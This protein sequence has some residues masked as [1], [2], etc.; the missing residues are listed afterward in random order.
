METSPAAKSD[1]ISGTGD[2]Q[3]FEILDPDDVRAVPDTVDFI[4]KVKAISPSIVRGPKAYPRLP[5]IRALLG[6]YLTNSRIN[7]VTALQYALANKLAL[8]DVGGFDDWVPDRT[9][10]SRIFTAMA[11][12]PDIMD[13]LGA[14][15]VVSMQRVLPDLG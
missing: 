6:G 8:K 3:R 15:V 2:L 4:S 10:L 11:D 7:S 1:S 12:H 13:D 14:Q 5:I 9:I